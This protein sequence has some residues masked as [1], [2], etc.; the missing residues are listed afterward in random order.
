M[1]EEQS[2]TTLDKILDWLDERMGIYGHTLRPSPRYGFRLDYW[3]GSFV[4]G[5]FLFEV[6][7]GMLVAVYYVPGDPYKSTVFLIQ[8]VPYGGLLFSLHS[9]GAY[10]MVFFLLVHMTRN[11]IEGAYRKPREIMWIVGSLLAGLTLTEAFLGYSLPYNLISWTATT[12]GLNLFTYMPFN[13]GSLIS[14]FTLL[15]SL[16]GIASDVDPLIQRFFVFHWI[17]GFLIGAVLG[18]HMYIFE[19]HGLTPP[20]TKQPNMPELLDEYP[21]K[22]RNDPNWKLQPLTR[23]FAMIVMTMMMVFGIIFL[24]SSIDPFNIQATVSGL[25]YLMPAYNPA[26]AAQTPPIPDWY[27]LFVYFFFKSVTPTLASDIFLAWAAVTALFPFIDQYIFRHK[28][29]HPVMRPAAISLGAAFIAMFIVN[30]VWA[31]LTPGKDIGPIGV[32]VDGL[33]ILLSFAII[34]ST[35][36]FLQSRNTESQGSGTTFWR[37]FSSSKALN[38]SMASATTSR[39]NPKVLLRSL[40]FS[41]ITLLILIAYIT[42]R[43]ITVLSE[44]GVTTILQFEGGQLIGTDLILGSMLLYIYVNFLGDQR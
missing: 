25:K 40:E 13:L 43:L 20:S 31:G 21:D 9:W 18:L 12:T 16:P 17:V 24:I 39:I 14:T 19:K 33:I 42:F 10:A 26:L 27:F 41:A 2:K 6:I 32:E 36:R 22:L 4:L 28:A 37:S 8:N 11:F 15:P 34:M 5:S 3:L 35:L 29:P 38:R 30:S 23:T 1:V 7:S 44:G